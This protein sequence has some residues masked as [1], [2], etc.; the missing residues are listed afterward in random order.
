MTAREWTAVREA[1]IAADVR[2]IQ[3]AMAQGDK[4]AVKLAA[5]NAGRLMNAIRRVLILD[6]LPEF[7]ASSDAFC[8]ATANLTH[9]PLAAPHAAEEVA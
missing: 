9:K 3:S 8:E 5:G 4:P 7:D 2:L 1:L 6:A